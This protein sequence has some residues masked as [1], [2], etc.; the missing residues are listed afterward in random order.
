MKQNWSLMNWRWYLMQELERYAPPGERRLPLNNLKRCKRASHHGA[1][2]VCGREW[3]CTKL[4]AAC[5]KADALMESI[6]P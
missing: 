1:K 3:P 2:C 4:I 6:T 5:R